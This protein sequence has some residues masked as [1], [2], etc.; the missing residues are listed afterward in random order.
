MANQVKSG[1]TN[2]LELQPQDSTPLYR[3]LY[4]RLRLAI[5]T[6]QLIAGVQLPSTRSLAS[7]L[8]ISR[9]TVLLAYDQLLAEG[10]VEGKVGSGTTVAYV[11]P[12]TLLSPAKTKS[13]PQFEHQQ[14]S[15]KR[16]SQRGTALV[17][18]PLIPKPLQTSKGKQQRIFRPG[19]S[20]V[21]AFPHELW[22]QL[23]ARR[24]R[25]SLQNLLT[26]H[27]LAGYR[28]LREAIAAHIV[29]ARGVRCTAD[30]IIMV[31]GFQGGFDLAARVLLDPGDPVWMEDP[32]YLGARGALI[33]AGANLVPVPV[34]TEGLDI[35]AGIAKC[36]QPR[37]IYVTPSHQF[38]L[39]VTMSLTRRLALLEWAN[40]NGTWILEDDYDSEYRFVGRPL[41]ALQGI[42]ISN[43]VIYFGTFSKVLFP[44]LRLG[45]LV[46]P[47][48][49]VEA[50]IAV[51]H[52]IGTR[53][54]IL[55]QAVLADFMN[56]G[57]FNRHI[58]RMRSLYAQRRATLV[59]ALERELE[60]EIYAPETGMHLVLWLP[61][62]MDDKLASQQ[63]AAVG[64]D[65]MPLSL[66]SITETKAGLLLG[67]AAVDVHEIHDGVHRLAKALRAI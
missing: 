66:F 9:N 23:I 58:R 28:P 49:L 44:A 26:D 33:G 60:F 5:L 4:E 8:G 17:K 39:G 56:E 55:E 32:G 42:D 64:I 12:E 7:E 24:A 50:F 51:R 34:D 43:C 25:N 30:Q 31:A 45:Y 40:Q 29:V 13:N 63:A 59:A 21:D 11:L 15:H 36:P 38:P 61:P 19:I 46:V 2:I 41:T 16:L 67:Y 3:Q 1:I 47:P 37:L 53:V 27:E 54:P 48:D 57:H 10:Y 14:Y 18:T 62:G 6:K 22:S 52:F 20:A 65:A 35:A